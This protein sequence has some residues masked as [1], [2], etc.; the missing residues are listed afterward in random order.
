[1]F[2]AV[3]KEAFLF[4]KVMETLKDLVTDFN[5]AASTTKLSIRAVDS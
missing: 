3:F 5:L 1:M 4:K 2:H